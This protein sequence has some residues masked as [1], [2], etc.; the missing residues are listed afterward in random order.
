MMSFKLQTDFTKD[1]N[2]SLPIIMAPMF[3]VSN[4]QM[5][6]EG[7]KSGIISTF[8]TLNFREKGEL[9]DLLGRLNHTYEEYKGSG[10]Y[11]VNL[12]VQK[13]NPLYKEHL[14]ICVDKKVPF[15]ITSLGNPSEVIENAHS[16]G[17]K[18]YCDVTTMKHAEKV[19][20]LGC[21]GLI[22]VCSGAGGHAGNNSP[23]VFLQALKKKFPSLPIIVAGG[24]ANGAG[25]SA[26]FLLGASGVSVGTRFIA[27][28][29]A[30]VSNEYKE[31]IVNSKIDDI[32]MTDKI[33][34][35]P[36]SVINTDYMKKIGTRQNWFQRF[37]N[38]NK[39]TKKYFKMLLQLS[40]MKKM[41]KAATGA[42]YKTL[43]C[44][45]QTVHLIDSIDTIEHIVD[46]FIKEYQESYKTLP[47]VQSVENV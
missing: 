35:T 46:S 14:N 13:T 38:N 11:G 17:A 31:A 23:Q 42:S 22:A 24:I 39:R 1:L 29:E 36:C 21:D 9:D 6:I 30:T 18:V 5:M 26:M 43:F 32:V 2:I 45:G 15:Y 16:Y 19:V 20:S 28:Q 12:I 7:M 4:E 27:T 8:P 25:M 34:G 3:L 33:S 41:E 10:S 37:L 44:A 40:S 47:T